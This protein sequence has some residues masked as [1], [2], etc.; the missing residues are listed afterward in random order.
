M[1]LVGMEQK[2]EFHLQRGRKIFILIIQSL[3]LLLLLGWKWVQLLVA[4]AEEGFDIFATSQKAGN[5]G[6]LVEAIFYFNFLQ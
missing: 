3:L 6:T 1:N 2:R 5:S 4:E